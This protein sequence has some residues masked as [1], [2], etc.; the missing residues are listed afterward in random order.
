MLNI[1]ILR[2]NYFWPTFIVA[3]WTNYMFVFASLQNF[4]IHYLQLHVRKNMHIHALKYIDQYLPHNELHY[5]LY[6]FEVSSHIYAYMN[7]NIYFYLHVY[8]KNHGTKIHW[9]NNK[10]LLM[11]NLM[12]QGLNI[13]P[14]CWELWCVHHCILNFLN[15]SYRVALQVTDVVACWFQVEYWSQWIMINV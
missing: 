6:M 9:L 14:L 2:H 5:V 1:K 10:L 3:S 7:M 12:I 15:G 8:T 4:L 11:N 13:S